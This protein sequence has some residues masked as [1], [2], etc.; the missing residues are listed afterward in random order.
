VRLFGTDGVRDVAHEGY[1]TP[2]NVF[3]LGRA[4]G[5]FL[6]QRGIDL[7]VLVGRDTRE[8]GEEIE[9]AL[10][11]GMVKEGVDVYLAGVLTTPAVSLLVRF[12]GIGGGV[13]ISASHN[14]FFYNGIKFFSLTG[15]K[16]SEGEEEAIEQ[17]FFA[18]HGDEL[19]ERGVVRRIDGVAEYLDAIRKEV[20]LSLPERCRV[21]VDC[22]NGATFEVAPALLKMYGVDVVAVSVEPDGRNINDGCGSTVPEFILQ[23]VKEYG[24]DLGFAFD[25]DGDRIVIADSSG[26]ILD[27]D[28]IMLLLARYFNRRGELRNRLVVGTV[29]SNMGF[30]DALEREN[31]I[32]ERV[33][34]GD[35][36]VWAKMKEKGALIGGEQSGHI[37]INGPVVTGDGVLTGLYFLI[38]ME[39]MGLGAAYFDRYP[40]KL[41]NITVKDKGVIEREEFTGY[42]LRLLDRISGRILIRPSGTEPVVRI[43]VEDRS[44]EV[45]DETIRE[46]IEKI[47]RLDSSVSLRS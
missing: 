23:K 45:V 16:L 4:Y 37:I 20:P 22:A 10:V 44:E 27:G 8:S 17:I 32:L 14:P 12:K 18:E 13:V 47:K 15:E 5:R 33:K 3:R 6:R 35:K 46:V 24:V 2:E 21:I 28:N 26:N 9:E 43:M 29:M 1:M 38:A 39:T 41:V 7:R 31:I 25:G 36:Y 42:I 11:E 34:V 19:V 40:Q 30:E